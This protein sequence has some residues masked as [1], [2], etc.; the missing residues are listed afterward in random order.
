MPSN[1]QTSEII[2]HIE[3]RWRDVLL[4]DSRLTLENW[5]RSEH[6]EKIKDGKFRTIYR[7]RAGNLDLHIKHCRPLGLRAWLREWLRPAKALLEFRRI[8]EVARR[9][10]PTLKAVAYGVGRGLG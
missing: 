7:V 5:L 3:P 8:R 1:G 6:A 9:N 4:A 2:W 10:V